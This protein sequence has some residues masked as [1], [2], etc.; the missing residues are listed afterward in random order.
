MSVMAAPFRAV[1]LGASAAQTREMSPPGRILMTTDA[2]GGVWRYAIDLARHLK[3]AGVE[4]TLL[5]FGPRPSSTQKDEAGEAALDVEWSDAPLDWMPSGLDALPEQHR[6]IASVAKSRGAELLHLN[7]LPQCAPAL[8]AWPVV[9][10]THSCLPTWWSA[11]RS[12]PLPAEWKAHEQA[13]AS[14]YRAA[15]IVVAPSRAHAAAVR[16]RYGVA[17]MVYAIHNAAAPVSGAANREPYIFAAAR[18]WDDAKNG[19]TLDA[20]AARIEWPVMMA[21][22]TRGPEGQSLEVRNA[23]AAG[24]IDASAVRGHMRRAAIFAAPSIYEP[25][26]LSVLEAASSAAA[27]VLSDIPTFRELW[28][29]TALFASPQDPEAWTGAL[30]SLI[31]DA[32]LRREMGRR[33]AD[34][35]TRY[36]PEA[37][38]QATLQTYGRALRLSQANRACAS[39]LRPA[40]I[41][42]AS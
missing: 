25:F 8:R 26:G 15:H 14:G 36:S 2:V 27:L 35:A 20:T 3:R 31:R 28:D 19:A 33:A 38:L 21:G 40:Q 17:R 32:G 7:A 10:F 41:Q 37:Q 12:A 42:M 23:S 5:G 24:L 34:R 16:E 39:P 13:N 4:T 9:G 6:A 30:E 29:G 11:V 22:A 18:W 1:G